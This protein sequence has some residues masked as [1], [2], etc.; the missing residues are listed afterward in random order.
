MIDTGLAILESRVRAW[1]ADDESA[2][3]RIHW[4]VDGRLLFRL[5]VRR[6]GDALQ[7]AWLDDELPTRV[8]RDAIRISDLDSV[9]ARQLNEPGGE[10]LL[11]FRNSERRAVGAFRAF[12][13]NGETLRCVWESGWDD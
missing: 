4:G 1:I 12:V 10:R 11:L 13:V 6:D 2:L 9:V 5:R 8:R 3:V 7:W